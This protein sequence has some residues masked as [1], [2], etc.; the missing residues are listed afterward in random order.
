[1]IRRPPRST[2]TDTLFPYTTLFRSR[3]PRGRGPL[4]DPGRR[5][6]DHKGL[7]PLQTF[8]RL[9]SEVRGYCRSFPTVFAS[10]VG[11]ELIAEDGRRY[12]DFF[13]GAGALNYGHNHPVLIDR[14]IE[15]LRSDG[16]LHGLDM[17]T[18]TKRDFLERS[19]EQIGRA[20]V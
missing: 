6:R 19:E 4:P 11:A 17:A 5:Q 3:G 8:E 18:T 16:I 20:H 10:A 2:R 15:H 12:L 7:I 14:L 9:E 13:A 1:M